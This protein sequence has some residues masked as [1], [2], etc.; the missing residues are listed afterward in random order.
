MSA[1][2]KPSSRIAWIDLLETIAISFVVLCHCTA[3]IANVALS[4]A[5]TS[6]YIHYALRSII[7]VCVPLFFFANGYLL[8]SRPFNLKKHFKKIIKFFLITIFWYIATLAFL[9][10]LHRDQ[11][12]TDGLINTVTSLK[13][14]VTHLWCTNLPL[15]FLPTP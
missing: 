13:Y 14:G 6:F 9:V 7:A 3:H 12:A 15:Y 4:E 10:L 1:K 8:L 2:T 5:G 11:L